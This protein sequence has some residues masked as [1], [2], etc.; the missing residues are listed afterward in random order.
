MADLLINLANLQKMPK[1]NKVA[2]KVNFNSYKRS[3]VLDFNF[4]SSLRSSTIE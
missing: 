4:R 2:S 1:T 3:F